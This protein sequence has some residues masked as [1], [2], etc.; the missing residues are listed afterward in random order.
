MKNFKILIRSINVYKFFKNLKTKTFLYILIKSFNS[1]VTPSPSTGTATSGKRK[2]GDEAN[3]QEPKKIKTKDI[4]KIQNGSAYGLK[5]S[6]VVLGDKSTVVEDEKGINDR[7]V[8][9]EG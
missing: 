7:K 3:E 1:I 2:S 4:R 6:D 9:N 8:A 5:A